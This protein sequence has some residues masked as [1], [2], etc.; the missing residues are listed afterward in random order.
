VKSSFVFPIRDNGE[1]IVLFGGFG[2]AEDNL[3]DG[4][5]LGNRITGT[6]RMPYG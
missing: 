1:G 3:L 5:V 6:P 2:P 4:T